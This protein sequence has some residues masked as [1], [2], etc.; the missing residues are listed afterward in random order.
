MGMAKDV[1]DDPL[2]F[3]ATDGMFHVNPALREHSVQ[4]W[5]GGLQCLAVRLVEGEI[6]PVGEGDIADCQ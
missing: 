4:G 5:F 6:A 2:A 3:D 1:R